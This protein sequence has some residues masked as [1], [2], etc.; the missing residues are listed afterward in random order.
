MSNKILVLDAGHS[1]NT[2][3]KQTSNFQPYGIIKEWSLN[4]DVCNLIE[5]ILKDY[6]VTIYRTDD[7]TGKT[8]VS[9][10]DRVKRCN[11][12]NPNLFVSIHHNA[13]SVSTATGTEVFYHSQGTSEDKKI[14]GIIAPKLAYKTGLKNRGVKNEKFTVLTCKSTAILCEGGFMTTKGDYDII[15]SDKGKRAYAESVAEGIIEYL[16]L[17]KKANTQ[18][19]NKTFMVEI[20]CDELNIRQK[21]DFNSKVV[22]TVKKGEVFTIVEEINGLGKLKSGAGYISM[23]SKYV[24]RK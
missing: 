19:S 23:N 22:G 16:G 4:S 15:T 6:N 3:G 10:Q 1:L 20:I 18:P 8:D 24:R 12:Y 5:N 17:K 14:A 7:K 2:S 9:L 11:S 13:A 21:A